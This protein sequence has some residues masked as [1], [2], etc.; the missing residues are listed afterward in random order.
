LAKLVSRGSLQQVIAMIN[1]AVLRLVNLIVSILFVAHFLACFW[2]AVNECDYEEGQ[3]FYEMEGPVAPGSLISK[4]G[5]SNG[6]S[7]IWFS[8]YLAAFYWVIATMMAVGYGDIYGSNKRERMYAIFVQIVG[9]GCFGFII[10]TTTQ[11]VETMSPETRIRKSELGKR[12]SRARVGGLRGLVVDAIERCIL[13]A[14]I[15]PPS[16][17]LPPSPQNSFS[18]TAN[19]ETSPRPSIDD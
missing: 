12:W 8:Q 4:C 2:A 9:A 18:S 15:H 14:L 5:N 1:P 17:S 3:T 13:C 16:P 7:A 11:I 19:I 10:S 6:V